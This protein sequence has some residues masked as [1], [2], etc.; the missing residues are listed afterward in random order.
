MG[1][2]EIVPLDSG[3][4]VFH[5]IRTSVVSCPDARVA[6]TAAWAAWLPAR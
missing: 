4:G 3:A 1:E 2:G 6:P 5:A